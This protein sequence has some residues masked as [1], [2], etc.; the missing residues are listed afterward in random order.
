M[1][2]QIKTNNREETV[3]AARQIGLSL[4]AGDVVC[5]TGGLGA[6]KTAFAAG[7]AQGLEVEDYV[8]SPT[9]TIVNEYQGRL[10][11]F[12]FDVYRVYDPEALYEI[13][14]EEYFERGGVVCIEWPNLILDLLPPR[15]ID[16][17]IQVPEAAAHPDER[18]I[19]VRR[20]ELI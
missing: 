2:Q 14:F 17:Q 13:G 16:I 20:P 4:Q 18:E 15:Y 12:H 3:E 8:T 19:I 10:P 9:F 1:M 7:L 6:G 5:L 11:F